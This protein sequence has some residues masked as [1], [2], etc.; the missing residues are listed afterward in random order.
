[1]QDR[2][3]EPGRGGTLLAAPGRMGS[4]PWRSQ[5][6][7]RPGEPSSLPALGSQD[8]RVLVAPQALSLRVSTKKQTDPD[9]LHGGGSPEPARCSHAAWCRVWARLSSG[10]RLYRLGGIPAGAPATSAWGMLEA[11]SPSPW[12]RQGASE[13]SPLLGFGKDLLVILLGDPLLHCRRR[14]LSAPFL[15]PA[16][17]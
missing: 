9:P 1:M 15:S 11:G 4:G 2:V 10:S 5:R 3:A 14:D 6:K 7:V 8:I 12:N 13:H 16:T 17:V